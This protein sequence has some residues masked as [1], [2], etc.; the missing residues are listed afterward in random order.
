MDEALQEF[1]DDPNDQSAQESVVD[2]GG[3]PDWLLASGFMDQ[4]QSRP[5]AN[6]RDEEEGCACAPMVFW[7]LMLLVGA[8]VLFALFGPSAWDV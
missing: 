8:I 4:S 1:L 7:A 5:N 6:A 3:D 2:L